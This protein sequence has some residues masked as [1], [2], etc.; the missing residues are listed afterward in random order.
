[1]FRAA[2]QPVLSNIFSAIL[3]LLP[4]LI[5]L[6]NNLQHCNAAEIL[7]IICIT[8][9]QPTSC[10]LSL[11]CWDGTSRNCIRLDVLPPTPRT[12]ACQGTAS[13]RQLQYWATEKAKAFADDLGDQVEDIVVSFYSSI[14]E[15][16]YLLQTLTLFIVYV[17]G[18]LTS[19]NL[20]LTNLLTNYLS[21]FASNF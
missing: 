4:D 9:V 8:K 10:C 18:Q 13:E 7:N 11:Q 1:M 20:L 6:F 3:K 16:G 21:L 19:G 15:Q 17:T 5:S 2:F 12:L 14:E